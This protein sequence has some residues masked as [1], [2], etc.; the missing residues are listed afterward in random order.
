M[1]LHTYLFIVCESVYMP[2]CVWRSEENLQEPCLTS[3]HE[4]SRGSSQVVRLGGSKFAY[5]STCL[6]DSI[7]FINF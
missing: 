2:W 1:Y 3:L 4:G 7:L 6:T 5:W